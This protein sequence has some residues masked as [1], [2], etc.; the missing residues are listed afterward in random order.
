MIK[1]KY[2]L[3]L[4]L[5]V[6]IVFSLSGC[7]MS[8]KTRSMKISSKDLLTYVESSDRNIFFSNKKLQDMKKVTASGVLEMYIDEETL[9]VCVLNTISGKLWRSL[10]YSDTKQESANLTADIIIKGREYTLNSQKDSLALGTASYETDGNTLTI[11]YNFSRSLEN[12]KKLDITVPLKLTLADGTLLVNLD[13][14][15][16]NNSSDTDVYIKSIDVLPFLGAD[17]KGE[18]GDFILLPSSSGVILDT[19]SAVKSFE[20]ISL[21]VYGED[22]A[23]SK[24]AV[25]YVPIASFG[26]KKGN[27]AFICLINEGDTIAEIKAQK[28]LKNGTANSVYSS[29]NITPTVI[30][31]DTLYMAKESY[32]GNIS[33]SYRFL[34]GNN[35]DYITMA[36][37][38]RELLIRQGIL[39]NT[40]KNQGKDYPF[41]LTLISDTAEKGQTTTEQEAKELI[42]SLMTKGISNIDII[43]RGESKDYASSLSDYAKN[44]GLSLSLEEKLFSYSKKSKTLV[45]EKMSLCLSDIS[46]KADTVINNMRHLGSGVCL[47]DCG[48]I[49]PTDYSTKGGSR[50]NALSLISDICTKLSSHGTLTVSKG[51][52]YTLK[53]ADNLINIPEYSNPESNQYCRSVPFLQAI[54]HGICDYSFT[55]INLSEDPIKAMLKSIEY[56]AVPHYEWYFTSADENDPYHYM[57]SLSQARLV[58]ENMKNMFSDL[59]DQRITSHEEIKENVMRTVYSSGSEIYVNYNNKAVTVSGITLDPQ[60]FMRVN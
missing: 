2:I 8:S 16:I 50:Q 22:I 11:T 25:S 21:P 29:F 55:A 51:N 57:N 39:R 13:C 34:N 10:P 32:K 40:D 52:I 19:E 46:S 14:K 45:G 3:S 60:G 23:E 42:T 27:N 56:G 28:A 47:T 58:Y 18:K 6:I 41:S 9:S 17:N 33:L 15:N 54:L 26:M 7:S 20:E 36:G 38:C 35:A 43:L 5:A 37:A 48:N 44:E 24:E 12:N 53:Y 49:L 30:S 4:L 1:L 31:D 59:Q